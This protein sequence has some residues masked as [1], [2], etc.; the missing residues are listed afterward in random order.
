MYTVNV[1]YMMVFSTDVILNI[2]GA[3]P[4]CGTLDSLCAK[5]HFQYL[6]VVM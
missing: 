3:V 6:A 2:F 1:I 5:C 4:V